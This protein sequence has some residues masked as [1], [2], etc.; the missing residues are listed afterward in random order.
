MDTGDKRVSMADSTSTL[1]EKDKETRPPTG[2]LEEKPE[3]TTASEKG[4]DVDS[5]PENPDEE[6]SKPTQAQKEL[7]PWHPMNNP[8]GGRQAWLTV[9][10]GFCCL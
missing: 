4:R 2:I 3:E 10:G 1:N 7:P 9:I 5:K 8:D 6:K